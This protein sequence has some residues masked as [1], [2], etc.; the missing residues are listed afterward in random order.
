MAIEVG[1][2]AVAEP[3]FQRQFV[4]GDGLV[5]VGDIEGESEIERFVRR[6]VVGFAVPA[7]IIETCGRPRL[8]ELCVSRGPLESITRDSGQRDPLGSLQDLDQ[9]LDLGPGNSL[10][11]LLSDFLLEAV[12]PAFVEIDHGAFKERPAV[13]LKS[14]FEQR[15][16]DRF[17]V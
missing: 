2:E 3:E 10:Q 17:H 9:R 8:V 14:A 4:A 12:F 5:E 11:P 15:F 6:V 1:D 13:V 7:R 16:A